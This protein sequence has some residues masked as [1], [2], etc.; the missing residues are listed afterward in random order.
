VVVAEKGNELL[1]ICDVV[2]LLIISSCSIFNTLFQVK[3]EILQ[4]LIFSQ[5][6]RIVLIQLHMCMFLPVKLCLQIV[7]CPIV[8]LL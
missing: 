3:Y 6:S 1:K 8:L 5:Q 4:A 2:R 7:I